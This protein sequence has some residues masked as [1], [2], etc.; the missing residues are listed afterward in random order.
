MNELC[1][2]NASFAAGMLKIAQQRM[3]VEYPFMLGLLPRGV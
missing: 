1:E 3:L 2:N